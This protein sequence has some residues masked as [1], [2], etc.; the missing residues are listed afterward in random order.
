M[1]TPW[2]R[3]HRTADELNAATYIFLFLSLILVFLLLPFLGEGSAGELIME[4]LLLLVLFGALRAVRRDRRIVAAAAVLGLGML[5]SPGWGLVEP[6]LASAVVS[7]VGLIGFLSVVLVALVVDVYRAPSVTFGTILGACSAYL[8]LGML[9]F[10]VFVLIEVVQPNSF[11]FVETHQLD[12]D[13][14]AS[15]AAE[16]HESADVDGV[17]EPEIGVYLIR[18]AQLFYYTFVT[19]TTLGYGDVRPL[20]ELARIYATLAAVLGQLFLAILVAR[21]VGIHSARRTEVSQPA[22]DTLLRT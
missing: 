10:G 4:V 3:G 14:H 13:R 19:L 15:A 2:N 6:S 18:R 1:K 21:L 7:E 16:I 20:S 22:P 8:M 9:W 17:G 12:L 11:A 5:A